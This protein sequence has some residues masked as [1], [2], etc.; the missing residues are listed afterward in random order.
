MAEDFTG[1]ESLL[2]EQELSVRN[3][4]LKAEKFQDYWLKALKNCE[5]GFEIT[6]KDE[7]ILKFLE[8]VETHKNEEETSLSVKFYFAANPFFSNTELLKEFLLEGEDIKKSYG[9]AIQWKEGK[10]VTVKIVKKKQKN[11]KTGEKK[12]STKEVRQESFFHFFDPIDMDDDDDDNKDEDDEAT[13]EKV[14]QLEHQHS[15]AECIYSDVI[16]NSLSLYL[17]LGGLADFGNLAD[18]EMEDGEDEEDDEPKNKK[19]VP[20]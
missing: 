1:V 17:G 15:L 4:Y 10:N 7:E 19:K 16:Q 2:T 13:D 20:P 11:K 18:L 3:H 6:D 8:R 12:V 14:E 5:F 9:D